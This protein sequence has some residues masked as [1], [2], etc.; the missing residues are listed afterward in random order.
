MIAESGILRT[1]HLIKV[2][3]LFREPLMEQVAT[4]LLSLEVRART[5]ETLTARWT[6]LVSSESI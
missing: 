6:S 1:F 4:V 3:Y 5:P 2:P